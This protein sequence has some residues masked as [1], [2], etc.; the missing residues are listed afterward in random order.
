MPVQRPYNPNGK[1]MAEIMQA[2]LAKIG[3]NAKLVT[4]EWG[5]Y[6]KRLQAGEHFTGLLGWTG[7]NG[8]PD[9]FFFLLGC[10]AAREGGQNLSKWCD[11]EF[12]SRLTKARTLTDKAERTKLYEEM[13]EIARKEVP[14]LTIAHSV[15]FEP[16]RKD[17][18][19]YKVSPLGRH[20]FFGVGLN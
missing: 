8:D 11:Q 19:D 18:T 13:Q 16:I 1:R 12:D 6:R 4:F 15:V 10:S 9:N 5:E 7:D 2:D 20:D 14:Q 17:V 3:V